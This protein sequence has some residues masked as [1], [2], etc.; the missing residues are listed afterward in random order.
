MEACLRP[1]ALDRHSGAPCLHTRRFYFLI[2]APDG[3]GLTST[4]LPSRVAFLVH[5]SSRAPEL[6]WATLPSPTP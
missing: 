5:F 6:F 1:R 3:L 2:H 4:S